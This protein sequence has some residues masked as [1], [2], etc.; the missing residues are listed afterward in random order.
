MKLPPSQSRQC[1]HPAAYWPFRTDQL[2]AILGP[3]DD[4]PCRSGPALRRPT[5]GMAALPLFNGNQF[6]PKRD[7][8]LDVLRRHAPIHD[9]T[10]LS[11]LMLS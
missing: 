5:A 4:P 6:L 10:N 1:L 8:F 11:C 7:R 3:E 9:T 2:F